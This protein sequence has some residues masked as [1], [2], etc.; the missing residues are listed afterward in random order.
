[1]RQQMAETASLLA[2]ASYEQPQAQLQHYQVK[3]DEHLADPTKPLNLD[4]RGLDAEGPAERQAEGEGEV[5]GEEPVTEK[6]QFSGLTDTPPKTP[7]QDAAGR[8]ARAKRVASSREVHLPH[9]MLAA[10]QALTLLCSNKHWG[11]CH[12]TLGWPGLCHSLIAFAR[13]SLAGACLNTVST[14][15][16]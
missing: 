13:L 4:M 9:A 3:L 8:A 5:E 6:A 12:A 1:M 7:N 15:A 10:L 14:T 2:S 16:S 11:L